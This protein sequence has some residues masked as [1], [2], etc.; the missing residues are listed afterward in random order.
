MQS[1]ARFLGSTVGYVDHP[2]R[3]LRGEPEAVS[4]DE[5]ERQTQAVR[6][7]AVDERIRR[8]EATADEIERELSHIEGRA[9]YLRRELKRL[10]R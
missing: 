2:S 10:A 3:G 9:R 6:R 8:R 5:Q 1:D 4:E 7:Q